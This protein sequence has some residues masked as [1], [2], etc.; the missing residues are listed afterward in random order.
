MSV[1]AL[2]SAPRSIHTSA[3]IKVIDVDADTLSFIITHFNFPPIYFLLLATT[4]SVHAIYPAE[5]S[6]Y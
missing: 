1:G 3:G 5:A 6:K 2:A 4:K